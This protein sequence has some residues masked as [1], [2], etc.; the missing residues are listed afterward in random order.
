MRL[1]ITGAR[2]FLGST[3]ARIASELEWTIHGL[4]R[5]AQPP[6]GWIGGYTQC[7][8]SNTDLTEIVDRVEPQIVFHGA[9][10][11]SV[12]QSFATPLDDFRASVLSFNNLLDAARRSKSNPLVIY[13][14]SGAV[15]GQP[16]FLPISETHPR[17]PISPY[18]THKG[19]A[20]MS[21]ESYCRHFGLNVVSCRIFSTFGPAQRRLL[22]WELFQQVN[23]PSKSIILKG[24]GD[25]TRDF[26]YADDLANAMLALAN[27]H[28]LEPYGYHT[29]NV[30]GGEEASV[31]QI[32]R[33]IQ[34]SLGHSKPVVSAKKTPSGDPSRWHADVG[35]LKGVIP[36]FNP[37]PLR[38]RLDLTLSYWSNHTKFF[39]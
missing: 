18:G 34:D 5:V 4:G 28:S 21:A 24:T 29:Y 3:V 31:L 32:V 38:E 39:L 14:S 35:K 2:G 27:L 6:P 17:E 23:G 12:I 16:Q 33:L 11:A 10:T 30:S 8:I 1:L 22:I 19:Q 9:G 36:N 20:E 37:P 13:P 7:D 25:E 26:L 15:Y